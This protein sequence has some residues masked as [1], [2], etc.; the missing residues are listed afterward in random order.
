MAKKIS[1]KK[2]LRTLVSSSSS[3]ALWCC[4]SITQVPADA[5]SLAKADPRNQWLFKKMS[6]SL[7]ED[8]YKEKLKMSL[9]ADENAVAFM[10]QFLDDPLSVRAHSA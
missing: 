8:R 3:R 2:V 5:A 1:G 7:T 10:K 9:F 4:F 6:S